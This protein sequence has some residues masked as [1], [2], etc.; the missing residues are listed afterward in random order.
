MAKYHI[1]KNAELL[2]FSQ[3]PTLLVTFQALFNHNNYLQSTCPFFTVLNKN[4][5]MILQF[6]H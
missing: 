5:L 4:L 1:S 3:L 6:S 2:E